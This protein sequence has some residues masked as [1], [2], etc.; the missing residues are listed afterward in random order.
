LTLSGTG[1][2]EGETEIQWVISSSIPTCVPELRFVTINVI[3]KPKAAILSTST[4][5][6]C[7]T[8]DIEVVTAPL[9][10]RTVGRWVSNLVPK[11]GPENWLI[12]SADLVPGINTITYEVEYRGCGTAS[13]SQEINIRSNTEVDA[14]ADGI[15]PIILFDAIQPFQLMGS[16]TGE[17]AFWS[18]NGALDFDD[19]QSL[20]PVV[21][22]FDDGRYF[23]TLNSVSG[24]CTYTD[25]VEILIGEDPQGLNQIISLSQQNGL[26]IDGL[27]DYQELK[28]SVYNVN[29]VE[30]EQVTI[31]PHD[32]WKPNDYTLGTYVYRLSY[33]KNLSRSGVIL[34]VE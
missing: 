26:F 7:E 2:T 9:E 11:G 5:D 1:E 27:E 28:L 12:D 14:S 31:N 20:I 19:V 34:I 22:A 3:D 10:D 17:S 15:N 24:Q 30:V 32:I 29:G 4:T 25:A 16:H 13:V 23:V 8:M 33:G 6:T 18:F 21:R